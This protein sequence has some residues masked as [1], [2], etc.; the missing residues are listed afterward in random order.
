MFYLFYFDWFFYFL[1]IRNGGCVITRFSG[2][3]NYIILIVECFFEKRSNILSKSEAWCGKQELSGVF[4]FCIYTL[5]IK[6]KARSGGN[7]QTQIIF[8][9][10]RKT[11]TEL[12]QS[13][14]PVNFPSRSKCFVTKVKNTWRSCLLR[15]SVDV[16]SV[17]LLLWCLIRRSTLM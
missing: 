1:L 13:W 11:W 8:F 4:F 16:Y 10:N 6:W 15:M 3:A 7:I 9:K 12:W 2:S 5:M 17:S 14:R